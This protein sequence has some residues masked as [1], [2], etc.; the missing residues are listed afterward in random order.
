M[1]RYSPL[2][3][4]AGSLAN[5]VCA[6]VP[7]DAGAVNAL[8][9]DVQ[10]HTLDALNVTAQRKMENIREVPISIAILAGEPLEALAAGGGNVRVLA[11]RVPSLNVES[12]VGRIFPRFYIRGLGNTSFDTLASQPVS[13]IYDDIVQ[14]NPRL[15]GFPAFDLE[16][17]EILRGPQGTL[18]GRN[19][20]AGVVKFESVK[21]ARESSGHV[22]VGLGQDG[23][24]NLEGAI[25]GHLGGRWSTRLSILHQHRDDTVRNT[26]LEARERELDGYDES[27]ARLQFLYEGDRFEGLFNLHR[28]ALDGT[29]Q[30]YYAN[31]IA[32]GS[33][34]LVPGF[35]RR[36]IALD[37]FHGT[38]LQSWGGVARLDW[39]L[40]RYRLHAISGYETVA[41]NMR[42]DADGGWGAV[43]LPTGGG[44]GRI[45]YPAE[46]SS[47][48][49]GHQQFTQEL[50]LESN[51]GGRFDW[52]TGLFW[53]RETLTIDGYNHDSLMP[54][55]PQTGHVHQT[56]AN[57]AWAGFAS[58]EFA[59]TSRLKLRAGVRYSLDE[60]QFNGRVLQAVPGGTPVGGPY[61]S[62]TRASDVSWD[63]SAVFS[64]TPDVNLN[65]R[66]A[67]G[68]RAPSIAAG[69]AFGG[70]SSADSETVLSWE[71]GLKA[72]LFDRRARLGLTVFHYRVSGQ[73]L[74]AVGGESNITTL[75]NAEKT[76][77]QGVELDTQAYL[78]ENVLVTF[79]SSYNQTRIRDS[80]LAVAGCAGGCTVTSAPVLDGNGHA[81][82]FHYIGGNSLPMAPQWI[83]NL[84]ARWSHPLRNGAEFF[85]LTDWAYRGKVNFFLY[86]AVEFTGR[87]LL[88]GGLRAGYQWNHGD[89]ELALFAR[90]ITDTTR[91][92]GAADFNNLTAILNEPRMLGLEFSARF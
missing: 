5:P 14:E 69:L 65:T 19:T 81:T 79:G 28:R 24:V 51:L 32:P 63:A 47:R 39:E 13:L 78:G 40:G 25:G 76:V 91:V 56:Q 43:F 30:L 2:F 62:D 61:L 48:L 42:A 26:Y 59:A 37:G 50:R 67:R 87:A 11:A 89:H 33:N 20:P 92:V 36:R 7:A 52:Q 23:L 70:V 18:F 75:I 15:K 10:L 60:K 88:E 53:F 72:D 49:S 77:G 44:P 54:G 86:E 6:H 8:H 80:D 17:V 64:L 84:T 83:H 27:A 4:L 3:I 16:R 35:D 46:S 68:F 1:R 90:N 55:N 58:G 12:S 22:R 71:G 31:A 21:P 82:G 45:P 85:V 38:T 57:T 9:P 74:S 34:H 73:Q 41:S 29:T 66:I